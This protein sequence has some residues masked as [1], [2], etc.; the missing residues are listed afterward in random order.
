ML[1][2]YTIATL[3]HA[4]AVDIIA[5]SPVPESRVDTGSTVTSKI[6]HPKF[7]QLL[8]I[9][10]VAGWSTVV[11]THDAVRKMSADLLLSIAD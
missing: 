6:D 4:Q 3:S 1:D 7:G 5:A 8:L 9:E 2:N 10:N 11:A